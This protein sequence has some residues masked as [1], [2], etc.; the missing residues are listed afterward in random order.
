MHFSG[1]VT[2]S[3]MTRIIKAAIWCFLPCSVSCTAAASAVKKPVCLPE[4]MCIWIKVILMSFNPKAPKAAGF[5]YPESL[6]NIWMVMTSISAACSQTAG[7]FSQTG[8]T[9]RM[10]P[11]CLKKTFCGSGI[12]PFLKRKIRE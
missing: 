4:R 6:R 12:L 2:T 8:L 10:A 3:G 9:T 11:P 1:N 5:I 7:C